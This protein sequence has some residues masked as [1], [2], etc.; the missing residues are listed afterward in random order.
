[1]TGALRV[2]SCQFRV[3]GVL[4]GCAAQQC[5]ADFGGVLMSETRAII[6]DD[7]Y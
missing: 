3:L 6:L 5:A 4:V 1:M 2:I 7:Q